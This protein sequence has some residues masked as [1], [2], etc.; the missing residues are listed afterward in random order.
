MVF[1]FICEKAVAAAQVSLPHGTEATTP[2]PS[3]SK[4]W[5]HLFLEA[6]LR[7]ELNLQEKWTAQLPSDLTPSPVE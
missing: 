1:Y 5:H 2:E 3:V 7:K 6:Q 4:A